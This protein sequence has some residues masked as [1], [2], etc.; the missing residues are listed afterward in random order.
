MVCGMKK[1]AANFRRDHPAYINPIQDL[2]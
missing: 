2:P 1:S